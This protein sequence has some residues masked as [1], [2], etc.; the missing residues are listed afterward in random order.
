LGRDIVNTSGGGNMFFYITGIYLVFAYLEGTTQFGMW[1]VG[2]KGSPGSKSF[3]IA[4][5]ISAYTGITAAYNEQGTFAPQG[6]SSTPTIVAS[7]ISV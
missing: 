7:K 1:L 5:T 3:Y 4:A 2:V 6:F